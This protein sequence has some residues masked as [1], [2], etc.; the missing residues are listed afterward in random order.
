MERKRDGFVVPLDALPD[1]KG[2]SGPERDGAVPA[3]AKNRVLSS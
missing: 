2:D 3:V 1:R